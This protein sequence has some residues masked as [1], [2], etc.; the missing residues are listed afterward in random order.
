MD[1]LANIEEYLLEYGDYSIKEEEAGSVLSCNIDGFNYTIIVPREVS[2]PNVLVYGHGSDGANYDEPALLSSLQ[3]DNNSIIVIPNSITYGEQVA[4]N[5]SNVGNGIADAV[6]YAGDIHFSGFSAGSDVGIKGMSD[7]IDSHPGCDRQTVLL[8]D[9]KNGGAT[10]SNLNSQQYATLKENGTLFVAFTQSKYLW[11]VNRRNYDKAI[12]NGLNILFIESSPKHGFQR[13]NAFGNDAIG[14]VY[15]NSDALVD[16]KGIYTYKFFD[17]EKKEWITVTGEE[18]YQIINKIPSD[19]T[20][21]FYTNNLRT[22]KFMDEADYKYTK[23]NNYGGVIKTNFE[24][25]KDSVNKMIKQI[26]NS[27]LYTTSF[28]A[29]YDSTTKNPSGYKDIVNDYSL[30]SLMVLEKMA[31][32]IQKIQSACDKIENLQAK[33]SEDASNL[34]EG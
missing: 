10:F 1:Y 32:T 5:I 14:F 17:R 19:K 27:T 29:G 15:G 18:A 12:N 22:L 23:N 34:S 6:N 25:V 24:Y 13:D 31:I 28:K 9:A 11:D 20:R 33:I 3:Y 2:N 8:I 26:K 30:S 21:L 16:E 4:A 7:Y